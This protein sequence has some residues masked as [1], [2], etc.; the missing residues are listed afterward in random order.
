MEFKDFL[1]IFNQY[2]RHVSGH[3]KS[4]KDRLGWIW[5]FMCHAA[6]PGAKGTKKRFLQNDTLLP[7]LK[8]F[9]PDGNHTL[10]SATAVIEEMVEPGVKTIDRSA[11]VRYIGECIPNCNTYMEIDY[12]KAYGVS[13]EDAQREKDLFDEDTKN[14]NLANLSD[15]SS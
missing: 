1:S 7:I 12:D 5:D 8:L 13:E 4:L 14:N 2:S 11:F 15:S 3:N 10:E 6:D 9:D